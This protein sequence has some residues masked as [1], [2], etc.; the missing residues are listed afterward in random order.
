[1]KNR[2]K[3]R[4]PELVAMIVKKAGLPEEYGDPNNFTRKQ[5]QSLLIYI[6]NA[7]LERRT[8]LTSLH[9]ITERVKNTDVKKSPEP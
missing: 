3:A 9:E 6:E 4:R 7:E 2:I 8:L 5:L 1:M